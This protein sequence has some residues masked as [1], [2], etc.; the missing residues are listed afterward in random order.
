[1]AK[2]PGGARL[3]STLT[4]DQL[5]HGVVVSESLRVA[6]SP[7]P[8]DRAGEGGGSRVIWLLPLLLLLPLPALVARR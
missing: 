4:S 3:A 5:A 7:G 2:L 1:M 6:P 8:S